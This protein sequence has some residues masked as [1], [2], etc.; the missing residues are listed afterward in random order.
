MKRALIAILVTVLVY[1]P[2]AIALPEP[3]A[4]KSDNVSWLATLDEPAGIS[5]RFRG[6]E[7]YVSTL[8]GLSVYDVSKPETPQKIG[9]LALPHFENEDVDLA[10]DV[11]LISN[12]PSEGKG[13]LYVISI[14]DPRNPTILSTFDTGTIFGS[15][16]EVF[17]G[18]PTRG[19]GH[20]ASCIQSCR[21]VY[22]A[23]TASGID[24]VDLTDP[25]APKFAGNFRADEATG[26]LASHDVQ[27]DSEG[28]AW[29]VGGGGTASYDVTDPKKPKLVHRTN[30]Q[31]KSK[32]GVEPTDGKA[33]NDF[34]HHNSLRLNN[35]SLLTAPPGSDPAAESSVV[36]V[37]EEDY[38]RPTCDGAGQVE[39]WQIGEDKVLRPLDDYVVPVDPSKASLCSAHYFDERSGLIAQGWYEAGTRFL[40]VSNPS[41]IRPVGFWVPA[42]NMTWS[43]YYPPTDPSG[44]I[45]Y[46]LDHSRGIDVVRIA[47]SRPAARVEPPPG[48]PPSSS[49][50]GARPNVRVAI[51]DRVKS[52]RRGRRVLYRMTVTNSSSTRARAIKASATLQRALG[53]VRG[54][55]LSR[56]V[57]SFGTKYVSPGRSRT[58]LFSAQVGRKAAGKTVEVPARVSASDDVDPRDNYAVDRDRLLPA[59]K[60]KGT[61]KAAATPYD[62]AAPENA[63][64][65]ARITAR[66]SSMPNAEPLALPASSGRAWV[67][68]FGQL[69]RVPAG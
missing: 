54:G 60:R 63:R 21:Y 14:K 27:V 65:E 48:Q 69:C 6:S 33:L 9:S 50:G 19:T 35:S 56:G 15:E 11:L 13:V 58:F 42:K 36:V 62:A 30:D 55:S 29:I 47:R 4:E 24:V 34:I 41:D 67:A 25:R 32:Y 39:T 2:S 38:N 61:R 52:V 45:V 20:T 66:T 44:E 49:S 17:F 26:G 5:A 12:D 7:M 57:V 31:G 22:L 64:Q 23:G 59:A 1:A 28:L 3:P 16:G 68:T 10:G 53:R 40:D 46:S 37:T 18:T 8:R 43:V 51:D